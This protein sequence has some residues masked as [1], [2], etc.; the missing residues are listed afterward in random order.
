MRC[1]RGEN[2]SQ[3]GVVNVKFH[4]TCRI[5]DS[6]FLP[7]KITDRKRSNVSF[8]PILVP[9]GTPIPDA[10]PDFRAALKETN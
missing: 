2:S 10:S 4:R 6:K 9:K 5:Y 1:S 8:A 7:D 3:L